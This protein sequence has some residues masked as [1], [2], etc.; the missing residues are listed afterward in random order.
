MD[1]V[2]IYYTYGGYVS[3]MG[4]DVLFVVGYG[5]SNTARV[6][7]VVMGIESTHYVVVKPQSSHT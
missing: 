4:G 1:D 5:E 2:V 3:Y 6:M 7:E